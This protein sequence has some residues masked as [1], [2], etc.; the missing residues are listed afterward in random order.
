MTNSDN[1]GGAWRNDGGVQPHV[2][3]P[4]LQPADGVF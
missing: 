3:D 1:T 4:V 2:F